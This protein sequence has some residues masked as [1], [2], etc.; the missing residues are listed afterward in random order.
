MMVEYGKGVNDLTDPVEFMVRSTFAQ[1][2]MNW[3]E[4]GREGRLPPVGGRGP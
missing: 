1:M 3:K 4:R 2:R